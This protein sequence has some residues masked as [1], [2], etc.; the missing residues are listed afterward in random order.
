MS[1]QDS[2]NHVRVLRRSE[3]VQRK[4]II[5]LTSPYTRV[6]SELAKARY[7]IS[8]S[9]RIIEEN[10]KIAQVNP[11]DRN[12]LGALAI[13]SQATC[14]QPWVVEHLLM[15]ELLSRSTGER[16]LQESNVLTVIEILYREANAI[17]S[18]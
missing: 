1:R 7:P 6:A 5:R 15:A 10:W 12:C 11:L 3:A 13:L 16:K 14:G 2:R 18:T 8:L 4:N 17:L 9:T